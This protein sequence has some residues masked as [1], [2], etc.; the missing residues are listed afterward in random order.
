VGKFEKLPGFPASFKDYLNSLFRAGGI[1]HFK[2]EDDEKLII[3]NPDYLRNVSD[4]LVGTDKRVIA[5]YLGW[6]VFKSVVGNLNKAAR[7]LRQDYNAKLNG[8][9]SAQPDWKRCVKSVGFNTYSSGALGLAGSMYVRGY[10][11]PE[12]KK[13][14]VQ[15]IKYIR[16]GFKTML[17]EVQWMDDGTKTKAQKKLKLMKEYIAF[18]DEMFEKE[19]IDEYY[20]DFKAAPDTYLENALNLNKFDT[21]RVLKQLR[22]KVDPEHWTE[23]YSVA[24]VNAFYNGDINSMEF[25]AGILQGVFFNAKAPKYMNY[26]AIGAV[27]G[28]EITHGF[29]DRGR[30]Q[31]FEGK[32]VDWWAN[33]TATEYK[34]RAQC[35][36]EQYGN[37]TADQ[38]KIKLN[39]I[40]TQGENIADNGGIK[41]AYLGYQNYV[42]DHGDESQ[43]PGH[44]YS[45]RQ[46]F[47]ISFGQVWCS[48]YKDGTLKSRILTGVHSPGA[49]RIKGPLSN[50][51]D[52]ARDFKCKVGSKM[53]PAKKCTV[54]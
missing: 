27:I 34:R 30:T 38:I 17:D 41:E 31:D 7:Q 21:V 28:H 54:W 42:S 26:G 53:N 1:T 47:W 13:E 37:F 46:M 48:K 50:N 39:G 10:F 22:E 44:D 43:L 32:L 33:E 19:T 23:H 12:E 6:R 15:M 2:I 11:K 45:A 18:P 49:F 8:V 29:D 14:M 9:A 20:A 5:D 52:F 4:V 40:N 16:G 36:I 24:L 35:V 3:R 25:P 51:P